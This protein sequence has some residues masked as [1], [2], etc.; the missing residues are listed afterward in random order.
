MRLGA[1]GNVTVSMKFTTPKSKSPKS[2]VPWA[3]GA[4]GSFSSVLSDWGAVEDHHYVVQSS[5]VT[6]GVSGRKNGLY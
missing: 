5:P 3:P 6:D 2:K 4:G 1:C